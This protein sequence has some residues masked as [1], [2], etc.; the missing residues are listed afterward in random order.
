MLMPRPPRAAQARRAGGRPQRTDA[1]HRPAPAPGGSRGAGGARLREAGRQGRGRRVWR[2]SISALITCLL[3]EAG[4]LLLAYPTV[5]A[6]FSQYNQSQ[7]TGNYETQVADAFPDAATQLAQAHAYND[8]LSVGALLEANTHVPTGEGASQDESLEYDTILSASPEGLMAR[9]RIPVIDLD[10]PVYHGTSDETLLKGLG[11]LEGTSLPVGG[12]GTRSVVTGHR[13]LADATMFTHLDRVGEGDT[14]SIEV[15]G[16]VLV[17]RV[18]ETRVVNPDETEAL[19]AQEGKDL[20]TLVTCTPLGINT[21]RILVTGERVFPTPQEAIDS[22]GAAPDVPHFPWWAVAL[23]AGQILL[24]AYLWRTGYGA[25]RRERAG[26]VPR[27]GR[28]PRSGR[29]ARAALRPRHG[30]ARR[31]GLWRRRRHAGGRAAAGAPRCDTPERGGRVG[32][33]TGLDRPSGFQSG[34]RR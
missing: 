23:A 13:G 28:R 30:N 12:P 2:L 4:M 1:P 19:R 29:G 9:L 17:Y 7:V 32:G 31:G 26:G 5:A 18:I 21:H 3:A 14:F 25:A 27:R 16:E 10:L 33:L 20:M 8:A 24:G 6:W 15:F 34:A 22:A 11:H